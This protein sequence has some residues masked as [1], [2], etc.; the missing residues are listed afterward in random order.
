MPLTDEFGKTHLPIQIARMTSYREH[1][2]STPVYIVY[3]RFS[4]EGQRGNSSVERQMDID[5]YRAQAA[6]YGLPFVEVPFFDD[7][8]SG[9]HGDKSGG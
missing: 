6:K 8:K 1:M 4:G 9:Y 5:H 2:M 7:A 3:G